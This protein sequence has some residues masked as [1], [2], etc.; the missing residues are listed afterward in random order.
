[1]KELS[2]E[3][4]QNFFLEAMRNNGYANG[5]EFVL[6]PDLPHHKLMAFTSGDFYLTDMWLTTS[7][8]KSAGM[9][10][11]YFQGKPIWFM[12][13]DGFH[14]EEVVPFLKEV[15]LKT[16][17]QN[18]FCGGR[19]LPRDVGGDY[20]YENNVLENSFSS[21]RG[22]EKIFDKETGVVLGHYKYH[23]QSLCNL[24]T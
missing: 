20:I 21:F 12:T 16:Y 2:E 11:I 22:C 17:S 23:G 4:V 13:Y 1:M 9:T 8:N 19:G 6:I 5:G 15:L 24:P 18:K 14:N 3:I 7:S 10:T